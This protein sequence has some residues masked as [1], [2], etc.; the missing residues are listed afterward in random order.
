MN[1][2]TPPIAYAFTQNGVFA[3]I[4]GIN[5]VVSYV[6]GVGRQFANTSQLLGPFIIVSDNTVIV[7]NSTVFNTLNSTAWSGV[8]LTADPAGGDTMVQF[9]QG[10]VL[11]GNT[12]LTFDYVNNIL[13]VANVV[14]T[15]TIN[16]N[17]I[18]ANGALTIGNSTVNT[19]INST[20]V[21]TPSLAASEQGYIGG[22]TLSAPSG[23]TIGISA[24]V[25]VDSTN[26][27]FMK[28]AVFTKSSSSSW[29]VGTGN[30]S[31]DTGSLNSNTWYHVYLI[32]RPDTGV[33]DVLISLSATSPTMPTNYTLFRRIGSM[34]TGG[35]GNWVP[36]TQVG[37]E[38]LWTSSQGDIAVTNLST[39]ATL[40][41][42][43]VPTGLQVQA[44]IRCSIVQNITA[45]IAV[46]I[47]PPDQAVEASG[48][49]I[50][51]ASIGTSNTTTSPRGEFL[52]RTNTSGQIRAVSSG[53]STTLDIV[54]YGWVDTRG[55]FL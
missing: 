4:D 53:A 46:L 25:A 17:T 47:Q 52:V 38:F 8:S 24:G 40:Y 19:T 26:V 43:T 37:D 20:S 34:L 54:T 29:A 6:D 3:S 12:T 16:A 15:N 41:S 28:L 48:G 7:G 49:G 5:F 22:L 44:R 33:V 31:L 11:Q 32:K 18:T 1:A 21:S 42:L 45:G 14:N 51:N 13:T 50:G 36:F 27:D 10:G 35:S 30:G 39:T 9:N 23:T 2:L 55:K